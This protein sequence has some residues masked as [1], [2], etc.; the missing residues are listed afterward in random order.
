LTMEG[1]NQAELDMGHFA[2]IEVSPERSITIQVKVRQDPT[3]ASTT[4][5][6]F[7][8]VLS[9]L[10]ETGMQIVRQSSMFYTPSENLKQ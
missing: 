10:D 3:H 4:R 7:N 5:Q 2:E 8:F 1:L 9:P 6:E